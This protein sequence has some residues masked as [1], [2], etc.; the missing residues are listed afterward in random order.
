MVEISYTSNSNLQLCRSEFCCKRM[1]AYSDVYRA[2]INILF[3]EDAVFTVYYSRV[4]VNDGAC[5]VYN[6]NL[7]LAGRSAEQRKTFIFDIA[8]DRAV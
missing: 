5:F 7:G 8:G 6:N 1:G 3:K 4:I 2:V